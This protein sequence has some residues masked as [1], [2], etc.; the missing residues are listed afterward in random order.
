MGVSLGL[1]HEGGKQRQRVSG[2]K[3][4]GRISGSNMK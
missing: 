3:V 4:L 2:N 1:S